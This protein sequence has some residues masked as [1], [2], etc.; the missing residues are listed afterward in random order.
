MTSEHIFLVEAESHEQALSQVVKFLSSYQL[1]RYD[2]TN[3]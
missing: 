1:V 3:A 2:K